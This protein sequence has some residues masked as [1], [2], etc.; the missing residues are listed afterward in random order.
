[1]FR[2]L[3]RNL[4]FANVASALALFVALST[5]GAYAANTVF[6]TDI[7]DG[8]VKRQDLQNNAVNNTK[9]AD[10]SVTKAKIAANAV[11]S[12]R[13]ADGTL[14]EAD[15]KNAPWQ[16]VADNPGTP[17]DPCTGSPPATG[18]FCGVSGGTVAQWG[19]Y[20]DS[21]ETVR[22]FR[23]AA[24]VVHV[25]GLTQLNSAFTPEQIF[26]L[27]SGYRPAKTLIFSVD[28]RENFNENPSSVVEHGRI[29]VTTD[30]FVQWVALDNCLAQDP[31]YI[32][33]SGI[34]F[35]ADQ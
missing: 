26:V 31:G 11:D 12:A 15:L 8:E 22:F 10:A 23:D 24:G 21:F 5:G 13:V 33:L 16:V 34:T 14:Q 25:E 19:N 1:M 29:D 3:R 28:C 27:P 17:T 6:S 20:G 35:R 18:V 32:S 2:R 4:T 7:V 30:G 9:L